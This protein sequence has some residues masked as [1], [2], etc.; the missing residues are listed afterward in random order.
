MEL[1]K[2]IPIGIDQN[3]DGIQFNLNLFSQGTRAN[4]LDD[5]PRNIVRT[6][7]ARFEIIN[8]AFAILDISQIYLGIIINGQIHELWGSSDFTD[9]ENFIY[10]YFNENF[11]FAI[12]GR[13]LISILDNHFEEKGIIIITNRD[14]VAYSNI[15][16]GDLI[17]SELR[18]LND[19]TDPEYQNWNLEGYRTLDINIPRNEIP[20]R[21]KS[22]KF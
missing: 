7:G 17:E 18:R 14:L 21:I 1:L 20:P 16:D 4:Y 12:E 6:T 2:N 9:D 5:F 15:F 11:E 8:N 3:D 19:D 13:K 22:I 10:M